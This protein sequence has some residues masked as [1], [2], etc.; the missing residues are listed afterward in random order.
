MKWSNCNT[1]Y[2]GDA[3]LLLII[4]GRGCHLVLQ[5]LQALKNVF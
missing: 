5:K 4:I 1:G 2:H 3:R